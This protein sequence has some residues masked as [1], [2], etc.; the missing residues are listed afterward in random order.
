M[1]AAS[2]AKEL[3]LT[4]TTVETHVRSILGKLGLPQMA[5]PIVAFVR[6]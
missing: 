5:V 3:W 4:R 1:S 2:S 6:S